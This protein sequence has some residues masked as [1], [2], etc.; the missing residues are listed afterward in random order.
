MQLRT[1]PLHDHYMITPLSIMQLMTTPLSIKQRHTKRYVPKQEQRKS[2]Q[3]GKEESS[4]QLYKSV[5]YI[6]ALIQLPSSITCLHNTLRLNSNYRTAGL[7]KK[8]PHDVRTERSCYCLPQT[9]VPTGPL[10]GWP[11]MRCILRTQKANT[12]GHYNLNRDSE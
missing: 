11:C 6:R 5:C 2:V 9:F 12:P 10:T 7:V 8:A 4:R 3:E 1:A